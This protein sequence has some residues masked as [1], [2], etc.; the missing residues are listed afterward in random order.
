MAE[1]RRLVS[2]YLNEG[3]EWEGRPL[4]LEILH[5]LNRSGCTGGTVLRGLAGFTAGAGVTTT[6]LVDVG[7]KLPVV[8][9]FIDRPEKVAEVLPTLQRMAG[10]RLIIAEE[11]EVVSPPSEDS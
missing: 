8:V 1:K 10:K 6:S 7:N 3:D 11:V 2:I 5:F 4:Y 9:Q